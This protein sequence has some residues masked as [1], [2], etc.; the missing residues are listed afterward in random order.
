MNF[1]SSSNSLENKILKQV[2]LKQN[3][4]NAYIFY[5]PEY[6]GKKNEAIKFISHIIYKNNFDPQL[7]K[8]IR[9]NNH[10]DYLLIEPTYLLKANLINQSEINADI[11]QKNKPVIRVNQVRSIKTFLS[12]VSIEADKKFIVIDDAHLLNEAASN[13]LLKILEEP[14]NGIFILITTK[15]DLIIETIISRCQ[16]IKFS[17]YSNQELKEKLNKSEYFDELK[18]KKHLDLENIV[19]ISNG[20]LGKL[21]KNITKLMNI[22]EGLILEI[23]NPIYEYEKVFIIAKRINDEIDIESQEYLID[24]IQYCWWKKTFNKDI[25]YALERIK[26]NLSNGLNP[27]LTWEVGLLEIALS[28]SDN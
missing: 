17:S 7:I 24:Y 20:S 19:F 9:E 28:Q 22:S 2:I 4:S 21:Y 8:K 14:S 13:C 5:G 27:L 10:P 25:A 15:I 23:K 1:N 12:R 26:T 6:V 11:K 16:K 3:F 18:N